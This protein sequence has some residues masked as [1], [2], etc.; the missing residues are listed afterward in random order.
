[1][2]I[3]LFSAPFFEVLNFYAGLKIKCDGIHHLGETIK[4]TC[5]MGIL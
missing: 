1:M 2:H 4:L 3:E 5:T